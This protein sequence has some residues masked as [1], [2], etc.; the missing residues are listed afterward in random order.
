MNTKAITALAILAVVLVG[1]WLYLSTS[2]KNVSRTTSKEFILKVE[3]RKLVSGPSTLTVNQG[4]TVTI[5]ITSD[6]A[7]E[8]HLHGYDRSIDLAPGT[9]G[10]LTLVADASGHFEFELEH[11]KIEL[12]ALDVQP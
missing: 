4:D 6:E 5:K 11:N 12:G 7:E 9:E 3:D 10:S 8:L 1:A 2:S